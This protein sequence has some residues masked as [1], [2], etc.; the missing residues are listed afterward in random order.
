[1]LQLEEGR[2]GEQSSPCA[3]NLRFLR[4]LARVQIFDRFAQ[5]H[6]RF[7]R[8]KRLALEG[9]QVENRRCCEG[10]AVHPPRPSR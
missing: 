9:M 5:K 7:W 8:P 2:E 10:R 6:L 3:R 4:A 1:M